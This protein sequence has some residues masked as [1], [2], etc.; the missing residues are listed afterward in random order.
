MLVYLKNNTVCENTKLGTIKQNSLRFS[1]IFF[2]LNANF[3][4]RS[5][6][7]L[8][9]NS[10]SKDEKQMNVGML[11]KNS[12]IISLYCILTEHNAVF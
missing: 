2:A 9:L 11:V 1:S 3:F 6:T 4:I 10:K 5:S 8:I 12:L 7:I